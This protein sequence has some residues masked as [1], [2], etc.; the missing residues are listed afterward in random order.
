MARRPA[1]GGAA[2][3][4]LPLPQG[5]A[6][7]EGG[8]GIL[9]TAFCLVPSFPIAKW[10]PRQHRW[11]SAGL[12]RP[13]AEQKLCSAIDTSPHKGERGKVPRVCLL[14]AAIRDGR[15]IRLGIALKKSQYPTE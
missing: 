2:P 8:A 6:A 9:M 14:R 5:D 11:C 15:T 1:L 3:E 7:G 13:P 12:A 10:G 4:R